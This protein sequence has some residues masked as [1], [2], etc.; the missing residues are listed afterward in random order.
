[1][2]YSQCFDSL[3]LEDCLNDLFDVGVTNDN[4][5]LIYQ[6]NKN[7]TV[8][9]KTPFGMTEPVNIQNIVMQV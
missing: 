2:D 1:M 7:N 9:V 4:L 6:M 5:S 3:I 8:K